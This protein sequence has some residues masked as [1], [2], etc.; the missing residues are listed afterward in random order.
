MLA[1]TQMTPASTYRVHVVPGVLDAI[2]AIVRVAV[3]AHRYAIVTDA[4]VGPLY[5]KRVEDAVKSL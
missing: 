2:G 3:R 1:Y 4:N 5:A